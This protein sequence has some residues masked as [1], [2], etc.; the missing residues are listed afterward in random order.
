MINFPRFLQ[1]HR[2]GIET[3]FYYKW[4]LAIQ[5]LQSHRIGIETLAVGTDV[6]PRPALTIAPYWNWNRIRWLKWRC[7]PGPYNRTVLE[8]KLQKQRLENELSFLTIAPYWNWNTCKVNRWPGCY[9]PYNRTVLELKQRMPLGSLSQD[10]PYNRTVLELKRSPP[11][12]L[13]A[14]ESPY[15]RTVLELKQAMIMKS[16]SNP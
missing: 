8:L 3:V 9:K 4:P 13:P 11:W 6:W 16:L 10:G 2:I 15:N 14:P 7:R 12:R 1:S 5:I